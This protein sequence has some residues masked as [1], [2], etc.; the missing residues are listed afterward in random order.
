M[1]GIW[2]IDLIWKI[3]KKEKGINDLSYNSWKTWKTE[4]SEVLKS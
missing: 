3:L 2:I 4:K 1:T